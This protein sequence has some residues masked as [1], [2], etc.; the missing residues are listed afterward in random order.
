MP[1]LSMVCLLNSW[2]SLVS[3]TF[4]LYSTVLRHLSWLSRPLLIVKPSS[5][6]QADT[7]PKHSHGKGHWEAHRSSPI[8]TFL[9][10]SCL[11]YSSGGSLISPWSTPG[12]S[13]HFLLSLLSLHLQCLPFTTAFSAAPAPPPKIWSYVPSL[14]FPPK[15]LH[16]H[17]QHWAM[18]PAHLPHWWGLDDKPVLLLSKTKHTG[19]G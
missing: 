10:Y 6:P 12:Y 18:S 4:P 5:S 11:K 17:N 15:T 16:L 13:E 2:N 7:G 14:H 8:T 9:L 3:R 19:A 1:S